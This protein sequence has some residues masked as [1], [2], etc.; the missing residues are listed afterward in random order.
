ML[1]G[2]YQDFHPS[3]SGRYGGMDDEDSPWNML[4]LLPDY[5]YFFHYFAFR[6]MCVYVNTDGVVLK[7]KR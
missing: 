3:E 2:V 6:S 1:V 7:L 5:G 4:L